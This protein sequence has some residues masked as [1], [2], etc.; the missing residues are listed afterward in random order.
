MREAKERAAT[1]GEAPM[2]PATAFDSVVLPVTSSLSLGGRDDGA[3]AG[4]FAAC[5]LPPLPGSGVLLRCTAGLGELLRLPM[6]GVLLRCAAG[7]G[8]LLRFTIGVPLRLLP[9]VAAVVGVAFLGGAPLADGGR[10]GFG[11][12]SSAPM[13][14]CFP[15]SGS[16]P[17]GRLGM[18][19]QRRRPRG[20]RARLYV[21][22]RCSPNLCSSEDRFK[23]DKHVKTLH[24]I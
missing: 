17:V 24:K 13:F 4:F 9:F 1:A 8:E 2:K 15:C 20:G 16:E 3:R 23:T 5:A 11:R 21:T 19:A 14:A 22:L 18:A 7:L 10:G 12:L 6:G